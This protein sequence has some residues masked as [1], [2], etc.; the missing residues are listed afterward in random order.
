M[1]FLGTKEEERVF[2]RRITL[3]FLSWLG[4]L[5]SVILGFNLLLFPGTNVLVEIFQH[6]H[7]HVWPPICFVVQ[8]H[9]AVSLFLGCGVYLSA[10]VPYW[11]T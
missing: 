9:F 6:F 5:A 2:K 8:L 10:R 3:V 7:Y 11:M 1:V 4:V